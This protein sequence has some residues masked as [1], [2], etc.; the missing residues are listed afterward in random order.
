[1]QTTIGRL[2]TGAAAIFFCLSGA[3]ALV[4]PSSFY[5][6]VAHWPPYNEHLV[7]D[8]GVFQLGIGVSLAALLV[9]MRGTVAVLAGAAAA[10]V[11]HVVSH[12]VDYGD[13]GRS[14][15]PYVLGVVAL[16]LLVALFI[17]GRAAT[18]RS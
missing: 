11:L 16:V 7:H 10:A 3:W 13:G 15:D 4:D 12:V 1:M 18:R 2:A 14:T 8:A 17:E 5:D 6:Q 9:G